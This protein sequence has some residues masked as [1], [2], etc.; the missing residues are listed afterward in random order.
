MAKTRK[1]KDGDKFGEWTVIKAY[2]STSPRYKSLCRCSCGVEKEVMN[3]NLLNG[4]SVSCG[5]GRYETRLQKAKDRRLSRSGKKNFEDKLVD[6]SSYY[7]ITESKPKNNSSGIK[8]VQ[9]TDNGKYIAF[10]AIKSE[11]KYLGTFDTIEEAEAARKAAEKKY[12][13]PILK[14]FQDKFDEEILKEVDDLYKTYTDDDDLE[15]DIYDF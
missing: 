7:R 11:M 3:Q 5:H 4:K 6:G 12:Y 14:D 9:L 13:K 1:I 10:I 2:S 8:G 15:N